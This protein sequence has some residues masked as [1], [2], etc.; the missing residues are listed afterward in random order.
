MEL[1]FPLKGLHVGFPTDKQPPSTSP[2]LQN[3]RPYDV[4]DGRARGGQRP[5]LKKQYSQQ[6]GDAA[7]P[8]AVLL[9][10]TVVD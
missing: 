8:I 4:L 10:I 6:I 5:G 7:V 2:K 9:S 1:L 3:V